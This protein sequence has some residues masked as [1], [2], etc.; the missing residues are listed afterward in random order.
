MMSEDT[1]SRLLAELKRRN[2]LRAGAWYAAMAWLL[3]QVATQVFP[4]FDVPN[5]A[6][7]WTVIAAVAGF[8]LALTISW[9]FELTPKGLQL[10]SELESSE[11]IPRRRGGR[12][13]RWIIAILGLAVV[14]LLADQLI[15]RRQDA[16]EGLG[17]ASPPASAIA[18]KSIAAKSIAV[19]PLSD[20]G[21]EQ[22]QQYFSDGLSEDLITSLSQF[23]GL[24]VIS[25]NSSFRFRDSKDDVRAIGEK[26]GVTHLL[27]G[28]VRHAGD[29]VRISAELVDAA[30]GSTLWS[31]RYDREYK[32]LFALQD[33]IA[34]AVASALK[35]ELLG[36]AGAVVQSDRPPSGNLDAY[37]SMLH[38]KFCRARGSEEDLRKAIDFYNDAIRLDPGYARAYTGLSFAWGNLGGNFLGGEEAQQAYAKARAAAATAISLNPNLAAAHI[39]QGRLL[40]VTDFDRAAAEAEY[41][42]ALQLAPNDGE[43]QYALALMT[44]TLGQPERAIEQ[45]RQSLIVDPLRAAAYDRLSRYL[46]ALGRLDEADQA[47]RTAIEMQPAADFFRIQLTV[48][49]V[50]RG[51]AQAALHIAQQIQPGSWQ[52]AALAIARQIGSDHAAADAALQNLIDKDAGNGAYQIAEVYALRKQPD[53]AFEWLERA[54]AHRD[55]GIL[56]LLNDQLLLAYKDDPRFAAFCRKVGL[57]VPGS[58]GARG[59]AAS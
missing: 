42:R 9:F 53:Q 6:V 48:I 45:V 2:V 38:G 5:W 3:V 30:D 44:G 54:R 40:E 14:L 39:A 29:A 1:M 50:L 35:A 49:E 7:R 43:A 8:P 33:E 11:S 23:D 4:F 22:S 17:A 52:D 58:P 28:S 55:P 26:L 37:Q 24:K 56:M 51:D 47:S 31:Q 21:G 36:T 20:E 57:P 59:V 34:T 46:T 25:R 41:R 10:E 18:A 13:D 32:D 16:I 15:S 27:E 19:I 12:G